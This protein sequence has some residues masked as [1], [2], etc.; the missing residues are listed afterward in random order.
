MRPIRPYLLSF[1]FSL[2]AMAA[3]ALLQRILSPFVTMQDSIA[4]WMIYFTGV[5][6]YFIAIWCVDWDGMS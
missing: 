3:M 6:S 5:S 4:W 1:A 2:I